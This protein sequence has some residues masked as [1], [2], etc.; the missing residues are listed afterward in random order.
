MLKL[1][2][3][4]D[5]QEHCN[6]VQETIQAYMTEHPELTC[7]IFTFTSSL[8]LLAA[9]EDEKF[10][11]FILDIVMPQLSG[12]DLGKKLREMGSSGMI[13]YL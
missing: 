6:I 13:I 12:I 1:A 10:N 9:E 3:C 4:D 11:L 5:N 8:K 7:K 2:L